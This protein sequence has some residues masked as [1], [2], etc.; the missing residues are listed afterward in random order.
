MAMAASITSLAAVPGGVGS[1]SESPLEEA[2]LVA[3][4]STIGS[5]TASVVDAD[6][7][8]ARWFALIVV[9]PCATLVAKPFV[10]FAL[11]IVAVA[12]TDEFQ[13]TEVVRSCVV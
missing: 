4:R 5:P 9:E 3:L 10:G 2:T 8:D 7:P 13:T 1:V 6:R 12:V 11:L